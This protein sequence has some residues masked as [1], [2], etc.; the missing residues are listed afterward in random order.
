MGRATM[1]KS[2]PCFVGEHKTPSFRS[3]VYCKKRRRR[4]ESEGRRPGKEKSTGT[5][6]QKKKSP[7]SKGCVCSHKGKKVTQQKR[8]RGP[9][10]Q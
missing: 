7:K 6:S 5:L 2:L 8:A 9:Y 3:A 10:R 4:G 1:G